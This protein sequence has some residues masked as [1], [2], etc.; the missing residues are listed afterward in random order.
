[1]MIIGNLAILATGIFAG[2]AVYVSLVEHPARMSCGTSI[3]LAQWRPSYKRATVM[4]ASLAI[5]GT[6][7]AAL[8]WYAS[9]TTLWLFGAICLGA[10]VPFTLIVMLPVNAQMENDHLDPSSEAA[11]S[12]LD[13]WARLHAFRSFLGLLAFALMLAARL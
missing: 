2:A 13:R 6:L 12:L 1:M 3:A 11:A 7:L 10:V 5:A 9:S 8:A 4:Q